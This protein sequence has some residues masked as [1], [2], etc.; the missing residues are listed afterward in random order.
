M[1]EPIRVRVPTAEIRR[2]YVRRDWREKARFI[3]A[4]ATRHPLLKRGH[5]HQ[6]TDPVQDHPAYELM[7]ALHDAAFDPSRCGDALAAYYDQRGKSDAEIQE[8]LQRKLPRYVRQYSDL[9][10]SLRRDG[11]V[12][13]M[14]EDEVGLAIGPDGALIKVSGGNHRFA[15]AHL[16]GV[17]TVVADVRFV[18][19]AWFQSVRR[20]GARGVRRQIAAALADLGDAL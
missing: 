14:D 17:D 2:W 3:W 15:L 4:S 9:A 16:L 18:H 8:Y 7:Q 10:D 13:G 20:P 12:G 1:A 11:Y 5:W 6:R 19:Q